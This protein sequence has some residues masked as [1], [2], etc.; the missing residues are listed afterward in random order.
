MHLTQRSASTW[1]ANRKLD[2]MAEQI[3]TELNARADE[4]LEKYKVEETRNYP[5]DSALYGIS[6]V[7]DPQSEALQRLGVSPLFAQQNRLAQQQL[8]QNEGAFAAAVA[9]VAFFT[10]K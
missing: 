4:L 8:Q 3:H 7:S 1:L 9:G 2:A 10:R 6:W 5:L